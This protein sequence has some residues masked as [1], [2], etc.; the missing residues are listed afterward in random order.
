MKSCIF[1]TVL[2]L[3]I[4]W[5]PAAVHGAEETTK[6]T[7]HAVE[8]KGVKISYFAVAG[9]LPIAKEGKEQARL[10]YVAYELQESPHPNRP[11]T[12]VFNGGPGAASVWLHLGGLGPVRVNLAPDGTALP[13][14]PAFGPNPDTW[15][16]FTDLVFVDP[17]G[18]GFSTSSLEKEETREAF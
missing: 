6:R 2:A 13:P 4:L 16:A 7:S 17:V 8:A 10:F 18:T 1:K 3:A 9:E 15:L 14:P 12:F 11:I 5:F